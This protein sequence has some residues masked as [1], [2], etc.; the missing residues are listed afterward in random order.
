MQLRPMATGGPGKDRAI[1]LN[2]GNKILFFAR[3]DFNFGEFGDHKWLPPCKTLFF[4]VFC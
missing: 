4:M 3:D 2:P 1:G